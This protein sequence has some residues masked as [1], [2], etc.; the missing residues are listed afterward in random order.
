MPALTCTARLQCV[1]QQP[2]G[3]V[4]R[5]AA[6]STSEQHCLSTGHTWQSLAACVMGGSIGGADLFTRVAAATC[7]KE[8]HHTYRFVWVQDIPA[9]VHIHRHHCL[10]NLQ[11]TLHMHTTQAGKH[12][13]SAP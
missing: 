1:R 3:R 9:L 12:P 2:E 11:L 8:P 10:S 7:G 5:A 4:M 6:S 13:E